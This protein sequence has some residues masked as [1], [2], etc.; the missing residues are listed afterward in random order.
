M[1]II[2]QKEANTKKLYLQN[3]FYLLLCLHR[4]IFSQKNQNTT[5]KTPYQPFRK[6]IKGSGQ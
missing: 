6:Y 4:E 5:K 1:K 2:P 3:Q